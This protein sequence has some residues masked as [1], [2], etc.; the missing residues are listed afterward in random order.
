MQIQWFPGHMAKAR[1]E[2][3]EKLKLVDF[4]IE[5]VD[6]RAPLSSENPML[7]QVLQ[8]KDKMIILMKRDLADPIITEKWLNHYEEKNIPAI[9]VDA[10]NK[11]DIK[12]V[13]ALAKTL[14]KKKIDKLAAK[15]IKPRAHRAMILGIPNVGKSTLINRLANKKAA[16]TGDRPGITQH[17]LWIKVNKDFDLLD[18]PG[19]LWPKFEDQ[20]VGYRLAAIGTIKDQILA[21]QDIVV[22]V[23]RYL[24]EHYPG[25][26]EERYGVPKEM[27]DML[28]VFEVIGKKRGALEGGGEVDFD[29]VSDLFLRDLRTGRLGKIT[30]E[31]PK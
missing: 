4:V 2:V 1:R 16:K 10:S 7:H 5:L 23:I 13:I 28:E 11:A 15:G 14:G 30:L 24:Q 29:K 18:T 9:A 20:S 19:I 22:Y 12:K 6:A 8:N 3:E 17:Q 27:D 31:I 26:L 21:L 25:L